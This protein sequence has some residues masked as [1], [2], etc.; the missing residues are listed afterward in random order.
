M[1]N[2]MGLLVIMT[3]SIAFTSSFLILN[4]MSATQEPNK[5]AGE[6]TV[7][8]VAKWE[9]SPNKYDAYMNWTFD[10]TNGALRRILKIPSLMEFRGYNVSVSAVPYQFVGVSEFSNLAEW[11]DWYKKEDIQKLFNE[12]R[13]YTPNLTFELWGPSP[14]IPN[15]IRPG[16]TESQ[17]GIRVL[18][19]WRWNIVPE[20]SEAYS[21][22]AQSSI[23]RV[24]NVPGI[25]ELR[26]YRPISGESQIILTLEFPDLVT[27]AKWYSHQDIQ[28]L[29]GELRTYASGVNTELWSEITRAKP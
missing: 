19:I 6:S 28:E 16:K 25:I 17:E 20:K 10:E 3:L 8:Y 9:V 11:A 26:G 12:L 13:F 7:L 14:L 4:A 15:P 27:W 23:P 5:E 2:V 1:R 18:N 21:G 22:W 29:M 24:L